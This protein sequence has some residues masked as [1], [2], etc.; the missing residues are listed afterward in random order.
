MKKIGIVYGILIVLLVIALLVRF[1]HG[2]NLK[3]TISK[4]NLPKNTVNTANY[5]GKLSLS[6]TSTTIKVGENI[7]V[8][9]SME[10]T[11]RQLNGADIVL[12][13]N[14]GILNGVEFLP[15]NYFQ[16]TPRKT[17]DNLSGT[18][19]ITSL[20]SGANGKL[21]AQ[22]SLGIVRFKAQK[23]GTSPVNF[24]FIE[25]GTNKSTLIE[26][27]T[28]QNILGEAKGITITVTK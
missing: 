1:W 23:P 7:D 19:K 2:N 16:L 28:S 5:P 20:D 8:T 21:S 25:G 3:N 15:G 9:I 4:Q 26:H 6:T 10:A 18:V 14:P 27:G 13:F 17:L 11:G 24:D 22:T 12:H